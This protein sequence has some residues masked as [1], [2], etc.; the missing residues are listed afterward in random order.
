MQ[1]LSEPR[2]TP[3]VMTLSE[4]YSCSYRESN[5]NLPAV[6]PSYQNIVL[7]NTNTNSP[8]EDLS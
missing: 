7:L 5:W 2:A 3:D 6:A 8:A 4:Y 1:K